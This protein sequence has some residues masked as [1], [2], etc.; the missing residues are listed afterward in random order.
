[1][2]NQYL[3]SLDGIRPGIYIISNKAVAYQFASVLSE[4]SKCF[5][6]SEI[7]SVDPLIA[8]RKGLLI[9]S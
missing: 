8:M 1:M 6:F 5:H 7:R 9:V 2:G 3:A 4:A